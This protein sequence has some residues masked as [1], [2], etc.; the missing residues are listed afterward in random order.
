MVCTDPDINHYILLQEGSS[1]LLWYTEALDKLFGKQGILAQHGAI[2]K[3]LK[4]VILRLIGQ[5]NLKANVLRE[6]DV[7]IRGHLQSWARHATV[8]LKQATA[9]VI[10]DVNRFL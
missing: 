5:E 3:Y 7:L 4:N 9:D 6:L 10:L 1:V 8:E 2:H